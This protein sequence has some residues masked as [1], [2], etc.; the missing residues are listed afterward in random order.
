MPLDHFWREAQQALAVHLQRGTSVLV[1]E[2]DWD[3]LPFAVTTYRNVDVALDV[4]G[5]GAVLVH[6]GMLG[7]FRQAQIRA[8]LGDLPV[9]FANAVFVLFALPEAL[10]RA[11]FP[12]RY[13]SRLIRPLEVYVDPAHHRRWRARRSAFLHV[14][15]AAGTSAWSRISQ[16][17]R[18]KVYFGSNQ[19]LE[20]FDGDINAFEVVGGHFQAETLLAKGWD[21]PVFFILRDPLERVLSFLAHARRADENVGLFADSYRVARDLVDG[22]LDAQV[23]DLL[24]HEANMQVRALAERPGESLSQPGALEAMTERAIARLHRP[25]WS[26]GLADQPDRLGM[27]LA[28]Q[29]GLWNAPMP[30][31]NS[32]SRGDRAGMAHVAATVRGF[33]QQESGRCGDLALLHA[34]GGAMAGR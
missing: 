28:R 15:K 1:P 14:P 32:L 13:R 21:G 24:F 4:A 31:L 8:C 6:K 20:A 25:G 34:A 17:V 23:C 30:R 9:I 16:S 10:T 19:A 22:P 3:R 2:G 12:A 29:F 5:F 7:S 18:S 26:F 33:F 27:Q 11:R